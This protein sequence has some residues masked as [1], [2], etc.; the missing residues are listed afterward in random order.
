MSQV[1]VIKD[2][3]FLLLSS[4]CPNEAGGEGRTSAHDGQR[5]LV[6]EASHGVQPVRPDRRQTAGWRIPGV[7]V[8]R[9]GGVLHSR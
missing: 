8:E 4:G 2:V 5:S 9:D 3:H 6:S 7:S 1:R